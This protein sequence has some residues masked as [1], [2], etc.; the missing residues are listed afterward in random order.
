MGRSRFSS[1]RRGK[2]KPQKKVRGPDALP[3][4]GALT[5]GGM[6]AGALWRGT[7]GL[8]RAQGLDPE[9]LEEI[10]EAFNLFDTDGNGAGGA[11]R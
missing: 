1:P 8:V 10:R 9:Q 3:L 4:E 6:R 11:G 5:C 7:A 2:G